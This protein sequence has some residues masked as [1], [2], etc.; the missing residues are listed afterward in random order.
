MKKFHIYSFFQDDTELAEAFRE[1][2]PDLTLDNILPIEKK[3]TEREKFSS[4]C[5][6]VKGMD[7]IFGD[8]EITNEAV[9]FRNLEKMVNF[10]LDFF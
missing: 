1:S 3:E 4:P 6:Y 10:F 9:Y 8:F 5:E 7:S 2:T